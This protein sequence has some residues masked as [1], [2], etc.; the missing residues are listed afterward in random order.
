MVKDKKKGLNVYSDIGKLETVLLH[1]PGKELENLVPDYLE[2]LLFD[3]IPYLDLA[4]REHDNF[5]DILRGNGVEVLYLEDLSAE[6]IADSDVRNKF[7]D[8]FLAEGNVVG[9]GTREVLKEYF[10]QFDDRE[11]IDKLMAGIRKDEIP[12]LINKSLMDLTDTRYP[13]VLDPMPNL[14][15]TRDPF[16]TIGH[17]ITL[18]RMKTDVRNRETIFAKYIFENHPRFKDLEVPVWFDRK[19]MYAL[20]GGD[21]IVFNP[22][23]IA[24]GISA[25]TDAAAI[26]KFSERVL[27]S[28]E[29]FETILAFDIP[30][31]RAFMHLDTVFT[32]VDYEKFT[33]H[34]EAENNL[35][36]YSIKK[37]NRFQGELSIEKEELSLEQILKKYLELDKVTLIRCAGGNTIDAAREQWNDGSNTLA[38]A[39]G[40]VVVYARNYVTNR[41]LEEHGIKTHVMS[42]SELSRGR[43]G[44]RCMSMPLMRRNL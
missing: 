25:R 5:A 42:C 14:Y 21:I 17:G 38:I 35:T 6:A 1:R 20:E 11:L 2:R 26:E 28:D 18:N 44:P 24:V 40:E 8:E 36:V 41:I 4:R 31:K 7:I 3:D 37:S 30:K 27:Y 32:M 34:P 9:R 13:F 39:P 43:G 15:F 23:V 12:K 19:E 33:I 22:K 29:H 16:A 10:Q